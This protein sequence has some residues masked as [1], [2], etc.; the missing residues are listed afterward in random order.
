MLSR[1]ESFSRVPL[2]CKEEEA[3]KEEPDLLDRQF[4]LQVI[5][6]MDEAIECE[7]LFA[8]DVLSLGIAGMSKNNMRSYLQYVADQRLASLGI[9]PIYHAKN[10][11]SFMELQDMQELTNFFERRVTEYSKAGVKVDYNSNKDIVLDAEF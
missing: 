10:P 1:R 11:F 4:D 7:M 9:S 8:D 5:K 3:R 2:G 6:M